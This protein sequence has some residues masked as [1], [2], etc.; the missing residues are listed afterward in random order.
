MVVTRKMQKVVSGGVAQLPP[1]FP[2]DVDTVK[3]D[4]KVLTLVVVKKVEGKNNPCK[5]GPINGLYHWSYLTPLPEAT[6]E[7]MGLDTIFT[8]WKGKVPLTVRGA[9]RACRW[10]VVKE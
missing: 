3:V 9:A 4:E 5:E 7:L 2:S 10:W 6:K 8:T 1:C